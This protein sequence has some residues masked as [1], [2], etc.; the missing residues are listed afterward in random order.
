MSDCDPKFKSKDQSAAG[1]LFPPPLE[2][3]DKQH[4]FAEL[5]TPDFNV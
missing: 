3:S 4:R 1:R 5:F 2:Q